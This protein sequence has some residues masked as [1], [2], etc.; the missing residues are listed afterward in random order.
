MKRSKNYNNILLDVEQKE[1]FYK[2]SVYETFVL[3]IL[4]LGI[5]LSFEDLMYSRTCLLFSFIAG[6]IVLIIRQCSQTFKLWIKQ[7]DFFLYFAGLGCLVL[8]NSTLIQSIFDLAN[9]WIILWNLRFDSSFER[10]SVSGNVSFGA[11]I[12]WILIA[13]GISSYLYRQLK[14]HNI[15]GIFFI[16]IFSVMFALILGTSSKTL[17]C[18]LLF[19]SVSNI[20]VADC[21]PKRKIGNRFFISKILLIF[22]IF[23][24]VNLCSVY[25]PSD[26]IESGK[27]TAMDKIDEIRYGKDTLPKGDFSKAGNLLHG[28]EGRLSIEI[29]QPQEL[30]LKGFV[31]GSYDMKQWHTLSNDHYEEKYEGIL[32]WLSKNAFYPFTQYASYETLN[33][34]QAHVKLN[35][36]K[37]NV[38]NVGAYRK[39]IYL[40]MT[41]SDYQA[42]RTA[43]DKDWNVRSF[44]LF[45]TSDYK[46]QS[47]FYSQDFI[48]QS[49]A[50]WLT[51][52]K[53]SSQKQYQQTESVYDKFVKDSYKDINPSL[54]KLLKTTFFDHTKKMDFKETTTRIRQILRQKITYRDDPEIFYKTTDTDYIRW[55]LTDAQNGNAVSYATTA[56]MAYRCAGYPAR[57]VEGYHLS[58]DEADQLT[59]THKKEVTLTSQNA[60]AWVEV[61]RSGIGW[62]PVEVVPGFYTETYSTQTVHGKPSYQL[63]ANN[64]KSGLNTE[65][66]NSGKK[67]T[68]Q[69]KNTFKISLKKIAS[70]LILSLYIMLI[71]Y[72]ILELQRAIR[73]YFLKKD[74]DDQLSALNYAK[75]LEQLWKLSKIS[76][77][78]SQPKS[79]EADI[80]KT[81]PEVDPFEYQRA[82]FLIQKARFGQKTLKTHEF[83]TLTCFVH[84][85]S[86]LLWRKQN[87]FGK[88][89]LRYVYIIPKR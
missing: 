42:M 69:K 11:L 26:S 1:Q 82:I 84:K 70:T 77:D 8:S 58:K 68:K 30:Y 39:Y 52:A 71:L 46:F 5:L 56:V 78:Y 6:S 45:G 62:I 33:A 2:V 27:L 59:K 22:F 43:S 15:Y 83:Y 55:L 16:L 54:K 38:K 86:H 73:L 13:S 85:I 23:V 80:I 28:K 19:V 34:K 40:P 76:G 65:R 36:S 41:V 3:M 88:I 25:T 47:I 81:Y 79:L 49:P 32:S 21:A 10:F 51:N 9:R 66:G 24:V 89:L 35:I 60:H 75:I 67:Q 20:F 50:S 4:L 31:G 18:F 87:F 37:V 64:D 48:D 29:D 14:K 7:I 72:L 57:Y 61:Y 12:L 74:C 44:R 53:N 63:R 17:S